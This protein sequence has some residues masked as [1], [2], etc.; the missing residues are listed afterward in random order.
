M[1][2]AA[3]MGN[4]MSSCVWLSLKDGQNHNNCGN[5][6]GLSISMGAGEQGQTKEAKSL[7]ELFALGP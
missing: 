1:C 4:C 2:Q 5:W 3:C 6:Y 7:P